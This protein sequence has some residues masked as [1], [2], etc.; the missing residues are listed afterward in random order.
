VTSSPPGVSGFDGCKFPDEYWTAITLQSRPD[1]TLAG[2]YK[3]LGVTG[4]CETD[5]TVAFTRIGDVDPNSI[6]DPA[7]QGARVPSPAEAFHGLYHVSLAPLDGSKQT[8]SWDHTVETECLRTGERCISAAREN[9]VFADGKWTEN[10]EDLALGC[11]PPPT[12]GSNPIEVHWEL[13]LSQP[14][15]DPITLLTGHGH[16]D[17]GGEGGCAAASY[18][19]EVKFE[20]TGD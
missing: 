16:R 5:R 12:R 11:K 18:N 9:L 1:G 4:D 19:E 20:R 2:Q 7:S 15:Q 13:P 8:I 6:P 10:Y 3:A 17:I 14:P